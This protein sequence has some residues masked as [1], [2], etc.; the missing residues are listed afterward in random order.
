M[1]TLNFRTVILIW[2][3][4]IAICSGEA[5]GQTKPQPRK[6]SPATKWETVQIPLTIHAV[7][8]WRGTYADL[9]GKSRDAVIERYG[10]P[11]KNWGL[12]ESTR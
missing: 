6:R 2:G 11:D 9:L 8:A 1:V 5:S 4:A 3:L 12:R 7:F 10:E